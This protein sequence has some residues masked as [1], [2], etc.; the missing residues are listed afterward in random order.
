MPELIVKKNV[1]ID[2]SAS[3]VWDVLTKP[4]H[5]RQWDD[6]PE[7]F[8]EAQLSMG[9]ELI[10]EHGNSDKDI[11]KLTVTEFEA[12]RLLKERWYSSTVA[13]AE[14]HDINYIFSLSESNGK[15]ILLLSI[16]DWG[17]LDKGQDFYDASLEF[18]ENASQKIKELA[19]NKQ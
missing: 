16:G 19:E 9:S 5:I 14:A 6:V 17:L 1:T 7:D 13:S 10:W 15:T 4:E 11:T 8:K 18:A 3:K 2:A 12:K